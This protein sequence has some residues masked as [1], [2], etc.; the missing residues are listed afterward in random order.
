MSN[1]GAAPPRLD[2]LY[3]R[4][5]CG[6]L[7][8]G[9]DGSI[10]RANAT[11]CQWVGH[12]AE[13]LTDGRRLQDLLTMGGRIF[14]QT[15][16]SPLLQ[17]Q[18]SIAEVKLEVLHSDGHTVP[19]LFNAVRREHAGQWYDEVAA[20]V[21]TDRQ[22][23]EHE[24]MLARRRAE[25]ALNAERQAQA[26]LEESR[27]VLGLAMRG[28]RM[29][30]WS[31]DLASGEVWWSRELEEL[32]GLPE[33]GFAG[34]EDGFFDLV[35]EEDRAAVSAAV[36]TAIASG[37]DYS[38]QFRFR[39]QCGQWRWME[40]RGRAVYD[41][42][43]RPFMLNGLGIDITDRMEAEAVLRRQ[44]AI[45]EHQ[46]DAIVVTDLEGTIIDVNPSGERLLGYAAREV[47]GRPVS[48]LHRPEDAARITP[49]A[50]AALGEHGE[51][52]S[53]VVFVRKDGS[54][55]VCESIVKPLLDARGQMYGTVGINHDVTEIREREHRL[56]QLNAQLSLADRHKDEFLA[57]LAHELRN[58]LA[59]MRNALEIQRLKSMADPQLAWSRDVLERQLNHMTHLVDDLLEVSRITQGKLEL[60]RQ[61]ID[62][63]SVV[64]GAVEAARP[65]LQSFSHHF[66][67]S[68]PRERLML[69]ADSTRLTQ[70][71][72]NLLNNAA[73]YTPAGGQVQL[74]VTHHDDHAVVSVRDSGI[75]IERDQLSTLF[76]MFSQLTPAL[77]R[78]HGGLGIGL[79]L[80][81]G[82]V[83]LHGGTV[84]ADSAGPGMGSEFVVRLP[85]ARG[86]Q[87]TRA[88]S[89]DHAP[90]A[91]EARRILVVD[92]NEDAASSLAMLLEIGGHEVR[93]AHDGDT[94]LSMASDFQP[95]LVLLD[96]GLPRMNGYE[97]ARR[98]RGSPGGAQTVLVAVTGWG[99]EQDKK[100][101]AQ[102]GFNHHLTKP[103]D[104][105]A[106][107]AILGDTATMPDA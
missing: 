90:A 95:Q 1:A 54:E 78:S 84:S 106:L 85:L 55:G 88:P 53:D 93:T 19:M 56:H 5:P 42:Q 103:V 44:A 69:D 35:H 46:T 75:G 87:P 10:R 74:S 101:A 94:A 31:R 99:Q 86:E 6:L 107:Q 92:D 89:R 11:F 7:L 21:V 26:D 64:H 83:E 76:Q 73:K 81:R 39:H 37:G 43:G 98:L 67:L 13:A 57:T 27:H 33:T 9:V 51:W 4:A 65:L 38:V 16:W 62:L 79:A 15:H 28:G 32:V 58:P 102:A 20:V 34:T 47:I 80:V 8:T 63:A 25:A 82:L 52:R 3:E 14:H 29:G 59:P 61:R 96:I 77:D 100:N 41:A 18:G 60:R 24:L 36:E 30:V 12:S 2:A 70:A 17:M 49:E 45:F 66:S 68:L 97:V 105:V 40:G 23:Y 104:P 91:S 50:L 48:M 72:L 71:I 22:K